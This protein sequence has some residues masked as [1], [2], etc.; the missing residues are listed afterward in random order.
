MVL[1]LRNGHLPSSPLRN[2]LGSGER[3]RNLL[4][5]RSGWLSVSGR[6]RRDD[7]IMDGTDPA[8]ASS[9]SKRK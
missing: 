7:A 3:L 1:Q 8:E 6:R 9:Y 5:S 4:I 2:S